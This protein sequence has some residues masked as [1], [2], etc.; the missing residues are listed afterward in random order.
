LINADEPVVIGAGSA[1]GPRSMVFTH[2]SFLPYTEGYWV[3]LAGVTLGNKVWCAAGVFLHPGVEIGDN[4]FVNSMAVVSSAIPSNSVVEGNPA[5]VIY[6]MERV[7]RKMS[8]RQVDLA[9]ER[10]LGDFAEMCLRREFNIQPVAVTPN[11]LKFH[12]RGRLYRV[13]IIPSAGALSPPPSENERCIFL[14]N[15]TDW[16]TPPNALALDVPGCRTQYGHDP[17]HTALRLFLL[18]YYGVRFTD[19]G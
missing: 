10:T 9:L 6:P 2:G 11:Q 8:P 5:K 17:V 3:K 15:C 14:V 1:L 19:V 18:R 16:Q 12:W 13:E 4:S 7:Q